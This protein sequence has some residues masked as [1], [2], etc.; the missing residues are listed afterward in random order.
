MVGGVVVVSAGSLASRVQVVVGSDVTDMK[1]Y[2][3]D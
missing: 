1:F 2:Q 3:F